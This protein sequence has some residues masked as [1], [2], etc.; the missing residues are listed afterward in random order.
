MI[1]VIDD[2][3]LHHQQYWPA[4]RPEGITNPLEVVTTEPVIVVIDDTGL[5]H[6]QYWP[7]TQPEDQAHWKLSLLSP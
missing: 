5:H 1:V 4:T 7:A 6:Q 2:T 3:G